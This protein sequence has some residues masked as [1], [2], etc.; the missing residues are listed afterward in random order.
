MNLFAILSFIL[1]AGVFFTGLRLASPDLSIFV[2]YPSMFIVGGGT[3]A[4]TATGF[5]LNRLFK[6]AWI[7][8]MRVIKG[9]PVKFNK[10]VEELVI[11]CDMMKKGRSIKE[12]RDQ[13]KDLFFKDSMDLIEDGILSKDE[14]ME[15]LQIR[16]DKIMSIYMED[17]ARLKAVSK[18]PPAFGMIG[19]TI[20]MIV[21]LANLGGADAMK[22]IGPAMGV[23]LI[24][25]LYGAAFANLTLVPMTENL[26]ESTQEVYKKNEIVLEGIQLMLN[27]ASPVLAAE[28]LNSYL[29]PGDRIDWKKVIGKAS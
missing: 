24:T 12:I 15:V 14:I 19:T 29:K 4:A 18:F 8:T 23:C 27:K 22:K 3:L 9:K 1:S 25:T 10:V 21:L 5:Q 13:S 6:M 28:K 26:N 17:T 11:A 7:S 20:G 16:L 2:D